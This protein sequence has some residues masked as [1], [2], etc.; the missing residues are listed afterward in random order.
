MTVRD[1]LSKSLAAV[2]LVTVTEIVLHALY[3]CDFKRNGESPW[4]SDS[5]TFPKILQSGPD[6]KKQLLCM[7]ILTCERP[8]GWPRK[9]L[10]VDEI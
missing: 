1:A 2:V 3:M 10:D 4:G 9:I 7:N 8:N 5:Q 6:G